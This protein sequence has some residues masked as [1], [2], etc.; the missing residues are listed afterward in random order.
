METF[1]LTAAP[2]GTGVEWNPVQRLFDSMQPY[3]ENTTNR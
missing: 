1:T 3:R 2:G